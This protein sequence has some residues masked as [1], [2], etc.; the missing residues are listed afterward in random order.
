MSGHGDDRKIAADLF[1]GAALTDNPGCLKTAHLGHPDIHQGQN[2]G[3]NCQGLDRFKTIAYPIA[4]LPQLLNQLQGNLL[5][6]HIVFRHQ[7]SDS[8][9][10]IPRNRVSGDDGPLR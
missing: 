10:A 7:D 1:P 2:V 5:V 4:P 6:H 8:A 3:G 9:P